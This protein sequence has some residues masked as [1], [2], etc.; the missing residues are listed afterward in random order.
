MHFFFVIISGRQWTHSVEITKAS[1]ACVTL[2]GNDRIFALFLFL[3][4]ASIFDRWICMV[5]SFINH[6][7]NQY[8]LWSLL[9]TKK[10]VDKKMELSFAT[11]TRQNERKSEGH[12]RD[13]LNS[14]NETFQLSN[15]CRHLLE[16]KIYVFPRFRRAATYLIKNHENLRREYVLNFIL[17]FA[18][19][20]NYYCYWWK[21]WIMFFQSIFF[22]NVLRL[23]VIAKD[24][25][26]QWVHRGRLV[27]LVWRVNPAR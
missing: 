10:N 14:I 22:R 25:K 2:C 19:F 13:R 7:V 1:T 6:K 3:S 11:D 16:C 4:G 8:K 18:I 12:S 5:R 20:V 17:P 23:H 21:L 24:L 9:N 15:L 26:V 27:C